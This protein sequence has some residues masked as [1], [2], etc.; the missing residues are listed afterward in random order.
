LL[1]ELGVEVKVHQKIKRL[2]HRYPLG[3]VALHAFRCSIISGEPMPVGCQEIRWV[4]PTELGS[5]TF[6]LAN[7]PLLQELQFRLFK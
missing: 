5:F 6:P 3:S 1:E 7:G 2:Q 4:L